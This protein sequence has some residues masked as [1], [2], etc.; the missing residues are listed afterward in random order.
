MPDSIVGQLEYQGVF[1]CSGGAYPA[2]AG[3]EK[4]YFYICSV[5][6][7][8]SGVAYVVGD[9]LVY[10]GTTWDKVDNTDAVAKC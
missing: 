5:G 7:T 6:G 2:P 10:N 9:W 1:D 4:G 8:I 3:L